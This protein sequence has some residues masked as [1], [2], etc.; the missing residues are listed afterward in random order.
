MAYGALS[1]GWRSL[2]HPDPE[3][4]ATILQTFL[5]GNTELLDVGLGI[6]PESPTPA[7]PYLILTPLSP[8]LIEGPL[9]DPN[10][11]QA[12]EWQISA[13][14][15]T[16]Q[17]ALG[18]SGAARTRMLTPNPPLIDF[19]PAGNI[20]NGAISLVPGPAFEDEDEDKPALFISHDTYRLK[21]SP[22]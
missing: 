18:G 13:V 5:G 17:Q 11:S 19:T 15:T 2:A 20:L 14:G 6:A 8:F 16:G 7:Y 9:N 4:I 12:T 21:I 22:S 3:H 1:E 10:P